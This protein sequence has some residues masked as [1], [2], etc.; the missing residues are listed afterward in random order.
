MAKEKNYKSEQARLN[1]KKHQ[2]GQPGANR[3]GNP[4]AASRMRVFYDWCENKATLYELKAYARDDK[5]PATRRR[6]VRALMKC[7]R[8]QDFFDLTNQTHGQPKQ[9][10]EFQELPPIDMSVFGVKTKE[11]TEKPE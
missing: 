9:V 8:V 3:S 1:E 4:T 5:N 10:V 11:D 2:F 7:E 6:F